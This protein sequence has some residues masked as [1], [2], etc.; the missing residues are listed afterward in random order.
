MHFL[1]NLD[2]RKGSLLQSLL[3]HNKPPTHGDGNQETFYSAQRRYGSRIQTLIDSRDSFS[4]L[5]NFWSPYWKDPK[6]GGDTA[7]GWNLSWANLFPMALPVLS[8]QTSLS[9]LR[10]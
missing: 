10:A 8:A 2:P 5:P 1:Q 3:L 7:M 4:L 9:S 6:A